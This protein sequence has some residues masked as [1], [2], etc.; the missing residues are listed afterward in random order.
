MDND[1]SVKKGAGISPIQWK[2]KQAFYIVGTKHDDD[3]IRIAGTGMKQV[4]LCLIL[5]TLCITYADMKFANS[6][7]GIQEDYPDSK[8]YGP[9]YFQP[10]VVLSGER[11]IEKFTWIRHAEKVTIGPRETK[12]EWWGW[13]TSCVGS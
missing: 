9:K 5:P 8:V 2:G 4:L 6:I 12:V 10:E 13:R 3:T 11:E 1:S 7:G